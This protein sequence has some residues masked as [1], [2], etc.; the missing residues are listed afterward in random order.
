VFRN[1]GGKYSPNARKNPEKRAGGRNPEFLRGIQGVG[2]EMHW[3]L[4]RGDLV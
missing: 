2:G 4:G 1:H 3:A